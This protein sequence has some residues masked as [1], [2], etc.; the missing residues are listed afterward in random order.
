LQGR[1]KL[2]HI[3]SGFS[4]NG[5]HAVYLFQ[6]ASRHM[7]WLAERQ[8]VTAAN[9]ANADT[10]GYRAREIDPFSSYVDGP[11]IELASTSPRHISP[12]TGE[13]QSAGFRSGSGWNTSHSGNNV[14]IEKELMT[15]SSSNRMMNIDA[16]IVRSFHRMLLSSVKA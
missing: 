4:I 13:V 16:S 9:I 15:A 3:E 5:D 11:S 1:D 7:T 6:V 2:L 8:M 10:P 14:S 12:P